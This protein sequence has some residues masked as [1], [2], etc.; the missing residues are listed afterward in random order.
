MSKTYLLSATV[1]FMLTAGSAFAASGEYQNLDA[2]VLANGHGAR[3]TC[4]ITGQ[5][6]GKTYCFGDDE[7]KSQF[8]KEPA[9]F[10]AKADAVYATKVNDPN[11]KPC[12]YYDD[13]KKGNCE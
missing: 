3:T 13:W 4:D 7:S 2:M 10:R 12:D 5:Y 11:W 8:M 1:I 9:T 6:E